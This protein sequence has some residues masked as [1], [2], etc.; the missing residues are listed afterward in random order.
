MHCLIWISDYCV[1]STLSYRWHCLVVSKHMIGVEVQTHFPQTRSTLRIPWCF[2]HMNLHV[3]R[4]LNGRDE[5]NFNS[6]LGMLC[7]TATTQSFVTI[8][9][10]LLLHKLLAVK[11][12]T[13]ISMYVFFEHGCIHERIDL[14][15]TFF[16]TCRA[17]TGVCYLGVAISFWYG[18]GSYKSKT[19]QFFISSE[20]KN[21]PFSRF[22]NSLAHGRESI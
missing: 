18:S 3:G 20:T 8:V 15:C 12:K 10:D 4:I 2:W 21:P 1:Y 22:F 9:L 19:R 6:Q 11:V 13:S 7:T 5:I 17:R 16:S 14:Y